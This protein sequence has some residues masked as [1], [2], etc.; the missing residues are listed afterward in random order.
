MTKFIHDDFLLHS[1]NAKR[2]YHDYAKN[3]PIF[4]FH[5]HLDV[6]AIANNKQFTNLTDIWLNGDHYKWRAM[7]S[8]GE[9]EKNITG[10]ASDYEKFQAWGKTVPATLA[11]PLYH[12]T[13]L[14]LQR[15]FDE[16]RLLSPSTSN[17]IWE[18]ANERLKTDAYKTNSIV[19]FSNVDTIYTTD[20]PL[21]NLQNHKQIAANEEITFDVYPTFRPDGALGIL[22]EGFLDYLDR[23]EEV[24]G[25]P[26]N[27]YDDMLMALKERIVYF[28]NNNCRISDHSFEYLPMV[29]T[30]HDI[31]SRIFN[32]RKDGDVINQNEADQFILNTLIFL[33]KEYCT[34]GWVMQLHLG[35][36][37]DNNEKMFSKLGKDT[38][39]DS[40]GDAQMA[41]ALNSFLNELDINNQLPKTIIYN[42]N[43]IYND[44]V[45]ATI[46]NFHEEGVKGKV[47]FGSGW[48]FNDQKDG[49]EKQVKTLANLSLLS[50]F[51]GMLTDSRSFLSFSRH[52]YFR[53]VLCDLAGN[54]MLRG[55]LPNDYDLIGNMISDV[56]YRNA[57]DYFTHK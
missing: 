33:G 54:W 56:S 52:E 40:M 43:P 36:L 45:A 30:N 25:K 41:K 26:I 5:S 17:S 55:E 46:G 42:L 22:H 8:N 27:N 19:E 7:R 53:R 29:N 37:R 38:G 11:N 50:N 3:L 47:Q 4:D 35:A 28:S 39:F 10:H 16:P 51:V 57:K 14:E 12:W 23:L 44:V 2:L 15:Y 48:W 9:E 31:A 20:D 34:H 18:N 32:K 21:S 1:E 49:I 6:E 24:I 13:H